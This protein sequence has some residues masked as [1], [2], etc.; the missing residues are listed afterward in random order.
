MP[1]PDLSQL[2]T[3]TGYSGWPNSTNV[4][5]QLVLV[6]ADSPEKC[7]FSETVTEK[8]LA[9]ED[10]V[11]LKLASH[12][13]LGIGKL[14]PDQRLY[15]PWRFVKAGSRMADDAIFVRWVDQKYLM[16]VNNDLVFDVSFAKYEPNTDVNMVGGTSASYP[17]KIPDANRDWVVNQDGTIACAKKPEL[18][19]GLRAA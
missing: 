10:A 3:D 4:G 11:Q 18:V 8:L 5:R 7:V 1:L 16:V 19:P 9:G 14:H 15:G 12:P 6:A 17:T 2:S 13:E